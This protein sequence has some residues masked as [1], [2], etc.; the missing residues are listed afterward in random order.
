MHASCV[1]RAG[2]G[3]LIRGESGSGKSDLALRLMDRGFALVADDRVVLRGGMAE[4]PDALRGMIEVRGVGIL[5]VTPVF[6]VTVSLVV[7]LLEQAPRLPEPVRDPVLGVP[8]IVLCAREA[9][10]VLK[11]ELALACVSGE[12]SLA[13]GFVGQS[14]VV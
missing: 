3:V 4:P 7:R 12:R 11:V 13:A 10:A 14:D 2:Q 9:S 1:S 6:P 8:E 5:R